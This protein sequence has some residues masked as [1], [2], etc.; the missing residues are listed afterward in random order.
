MKFVYSSFALQTNERKFSYIVRT[1]ETHL[2]SITKGVAVGVHRGR[3]GM[4]AGS[5][6]GVGV[7]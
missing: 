1:A 7:E 5:G 3:E 6:V 4:G 2:V